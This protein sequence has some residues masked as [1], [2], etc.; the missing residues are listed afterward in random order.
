MKEVLNLKTRYPHL[1]LILGVLDRTDDERF[2]T[3]MTSSD[4]NLLTFAL[5]SVVTL[6]QLGFDGMDLDWNFP[7]SERYRN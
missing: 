1:K 3:Q 6:R 5:S 4:S 7:N 2:F